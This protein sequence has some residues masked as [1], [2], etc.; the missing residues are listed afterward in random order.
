[1]EGVVL[2]LGGG[3]PLAGARV[4][5]KHEGRGTFEDY[6]VTT[7]QD[8]KFVLD[9]LMPGEYR[10]VATRPATFLASMANGRPRVAVSLSNSLPAKE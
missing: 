9:N 4:Q 7:A 1:M 8:G 6:S 5:L 3:E 2:K 10:L